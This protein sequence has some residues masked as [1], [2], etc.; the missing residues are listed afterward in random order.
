MRTII[1]IILHIS[2]LFF[3]CNANDDQKAKTKQISTTSTQFENNPCKNLGE[4]FTIIEDKYDDNEWIF[5][6]GKFANKLSDTQK[7]LKSRDCFELSNSDDWIIV[8]YLVQ[9]IY[10]TFVLV[11]TKLNQAYLSPVRELSGIELI[12]SG[13][14][15][16]IPP[17]SNQDDGFVLWEVEQQKIAKIAVPEKYDPIQNLYLDYYEFKSFN[18]N[19]LIFNYVPDINPAYGKI[20][21][22]KRKYSLTDL[23]KEPYQSFIT[24]PP[25]AAEVYHAVQE[26]SKLD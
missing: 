12:K 2:F 16:L 7:I 9:P 5:H 14:Y 6:L 11:N 4:Y 10:K 20:R 24:P 8:E 25:S 18:D 1:I 17:L 15:L 23:K 13:T 19:M 26:M 22:E 21:I 3:Y